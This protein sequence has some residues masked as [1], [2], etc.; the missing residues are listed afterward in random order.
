MSTEPPKYASRL[1]RRIRGRTS[2]QVPRMREQTRRRIGF[3]LA[4]GMIVAALVLAMTGGAFAAGHYLIT[5]VKQISPRVLKSLHGKQGRRGFRGATGAAG[6]NGTNGTNGANGA[7]GTNG[8]D[9]HGP[10]L[11][12]TNVAGVVTTSLTDTGEHSIATLAVASSGFYAVT[13]KLDAFAHGGNGTG[14]SDCSL[15]ALTTGGAQDTDAALDSLENNASVGV[16]QTAVPPQLT[17]HFTGP[18]TV[19]LSCAQSGLTN[20]GTMFTWSDA[21]IIATQVSSLTSTA[22]TA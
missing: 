17:H 1:Q 16:S 3:G 8:T 11:A 13:A 20:G 6:K 10:A 21:T 18:G 2:E 19:N 12:V 14:I 7:D 9:G 4:Q 5:S 22:V 15:T